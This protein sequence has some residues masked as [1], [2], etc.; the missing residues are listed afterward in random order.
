MLNWLTQERLSGY[1]RKGAQMGII[2][3]ITQQKRDK[4]RYNIFVDG[5][6]LFSASDEIVVT[7]RLKIGNEINQDELKEI[8]YKDDL[9]TAMNKALFYLSR[10]DKTVKQMSDYLARKGYNRQV[11]EQTV[12]KLKD[13]GYLNDQAYA[14]RWVKENI[15]QGKAGEYLIKHQLIGKGIDRETAETVLESVSEEDRIQAARLLK[16]KYEKRYAKYAER[17]KNAKLYQ[18]LARK[19]FSYDI[20]SKVVNTDEDVYEDS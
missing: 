11:I 8:I 14:K 7:C 6:Y 5:E 15:E 19:G 10:A 3:D 9:R 13:Y 18:A 2:T 1:I 16:A 17:E 4:N 20:I 12:E